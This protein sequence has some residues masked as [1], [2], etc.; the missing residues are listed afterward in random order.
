MKRIHRGGHIW[1]N[2]GEEYE[3]GVLE[4]GLMVMLMD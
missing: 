1:I 4:D 3:N 2:G